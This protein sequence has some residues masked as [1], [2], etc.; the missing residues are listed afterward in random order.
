LLPLAGS[1][2][3]AGCPRRRD[4]F[5]T[6]LA[7]PGAGRPGARGSGPTPPRNEAAHREYLWEGPRATRERCDTS[8]AAAR[9]NKT[10][11]LQDLLQRPRLSAVPAGQRY[12]GLS[13]AT[14]GG[15]GRQAISSDTDGEVAL[16]A[17]S[18][19]GR[20][21]PPF[22]GLGLRG[23]NAAA[24]LPL[25]RPSG[26]QHRLRHAALARAGCGL[27]ACPAPRPVPV[28]ALQPAAYLS[29]LREKKGET[30]SRCREKN[31]KGGY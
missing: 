17:C 29:F 26:E 15:T 6:P 8:R 12:Q 7:A 23:G 11:T 24:G 3:A 10:C 5:G 20:P 16:L 22:A 19:R 4:P 9:P 21:R 25:L 27:L 14:E 1:A 28:G 31:V 18:A 13:S 30:G 2:A